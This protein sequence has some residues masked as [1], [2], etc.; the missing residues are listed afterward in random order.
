MER[1]ALRNRE[2]VDISGA[3]P[4]LLDQAAAAE[5]LRVRRRT[6]APLSLRGGHAA[7]L[8]RAVASTECAASPQRKRPHEAWR[9][10]KAGARPQHAF[11]TK[12]SQARAERRKLGLRMGLLHE[13]RAVTK[14]PHS[15]NRA[16][17]RPRDH[18]ARWRFGVSGSNGDQHIAG[19]CVEPAARPVEPVER[20]LCDAS[21][22]TGIDEDGVAPRLQAEQYPLKEERRAGRP[23][24]GATGRRILDG[25]LVR[26]RA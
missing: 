18:R 6:A 1:R 20:E 15:C 12:S 26:P 14:A 4:G 13:R 8:L 5:L 24:L 16:W 7:C 22:K 21:R 19:D 11:V 23:R 17:P 9:R 10:A 25:K 2:R 3:K